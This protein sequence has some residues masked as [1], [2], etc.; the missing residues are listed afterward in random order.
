LKKKGEALL[1][2]S[3]MEQRKTYS[4]RG[5]KDPD[6]AAELEKFKKFEKGPDPIRAA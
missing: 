5:V 2:N 1:K 3:K 4:V 6:Q